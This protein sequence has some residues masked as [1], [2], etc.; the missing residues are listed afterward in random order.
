MNKLLKVLE[1]RKVMLESAYYS[2]EDTNIPA[3]IH[4]IFQKG[5]P[6]DFRLVGATTRRQRSCRRLFAQDVSK[7]I[8]DL[9]QP[10]K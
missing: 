4:E 8:S 7:Y 6:A 1:D 10:M 5:P 9:S 2:T 3:H